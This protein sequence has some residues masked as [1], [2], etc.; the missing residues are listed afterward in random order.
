MQDCDET[1]NPSDT[2]RIHRVKM[3]LS[4]IESGLVGLPLAPS[5]LE[6]KD[7]KP[8]KFEKL[9]EP[10]IYWPNNKHAMAVVPV[11]YDELGVATKEIDLIVCDD[12]RDNLRDRYFKLKLLFCESVDAIAFQWSRTNK[13]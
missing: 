4:K 1:E 12:A 10:Y 7:E 2:I 6:C 8:K 3:S 9:Y 13:K 11:I 5:V